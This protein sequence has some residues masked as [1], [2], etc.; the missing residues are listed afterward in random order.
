M[1]LFEAYDRIALARLRIDA[2]EGGAVYAVANELLH[3]QKINPSSPEERF[4][5]AALAR[6]L[7]FNLVKTAF[8][9]AVSEKDARSELL[10]FEFLP[11]ALQKL[12]AIGGPVLSFR[13]LL[14]R[15]MERYEM[16]APVISAFR[17]LA[18]GPN[19][20]SNSQVRK[21]TIP[22]LLKAA[23]GDFGLPSLRAKQTLEAMARSDASQNVRK[24]ALNALEQL[25]E[26]PPKPQARKT[27]RTEDA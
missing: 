25:D 19:A 5:E 18:N 12:N 17:D 11:A 15:Y 9:D 16:R 8:D 13:R 22:L 1:L 14:V 7:D 6:E 2:I 23:R 3:R 24:A 10:P 4:I 20:D 21:L 27:P 26:T